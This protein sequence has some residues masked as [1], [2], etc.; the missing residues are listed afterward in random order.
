M[1]DMI[2][3]QAAI[4]ALC[5]EY[6][7]GWQACKHYPECGNL[8][9]IQNLPSAS[10]WIPCSERLPKD[11]I[12]KQVQLDNGWIITAYFEEEQWYSIPEIYERQDDLYISLEEAG[13][14]VLAWM[15]LPAPWEGENR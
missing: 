14:N 11:S 7:G 4:D 9:A 12:R 5:E 2:S 1:N 15:P 6:C 8:K 10:Q 3:R 13:Y